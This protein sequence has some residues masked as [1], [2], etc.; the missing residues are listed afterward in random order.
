MQHGNIFNI[1]YGNFNEDAFDDEY[2]DDDDDWNSDRDPCIV[3]NINDIIAN[4]TIS[5]R[6][7]LLIIAGGMFS[8]ED[9]FWIPTIITECN[10]LGVTYDIVSNLKSSEIMQKFNENSYNSCI[11][12]G[13]GDGGVDAPFFNPNIQNYIVNWVSK[14][15]RLLIQGERKAEI[16]FNEW[17]NLANYSFENYHRFEY[18]FNSKCKFIPNDVKKIFESVEYI[19]K[20]CSFMVPRSDVVICDESDVNDD[21]DDDD[22]DQLIEGLIT[23]TKYNNGFVGYI[24]DVNAANVTINTVIHLV[25]FKL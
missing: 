20:C 17:F 21:D 8:I 5:S 16:I 11:V 24:G 6:N 2:D 7:H 9:N 12:L 15:G 4:I 23:F 1:P 3:P 10:N 19:G 25:S 22:D 14:G 18:G 13:I